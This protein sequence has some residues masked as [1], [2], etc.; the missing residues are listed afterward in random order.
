MPR[1][2][3]IFGWITLWWRLRNPSALTVARWSGRA[4]DPEIAAVF[5]DAPGEL[6]A[7]SSPDDL[8]AAVVGAEPAPPRT[9]RDAAAFDE[10]LAYAKQ[11]EQFGK[12]I[13]T[14]QMVV[15]LL[16]DMKTQLDAA[17][18]LSMRAAWLKENKRPFSREASMAKLYASEAAVRRGNRVSRSSSSVGCPI[19]RNS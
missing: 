12:P 11:R 7:V 9:F 3:G 8:W 1:I 5:A 19:S 17:H 14:Y 15:Q 6:L 10:A 2:A 13:S 16:A 18:L 4:L